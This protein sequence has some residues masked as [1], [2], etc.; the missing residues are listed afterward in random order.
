MRP[1]LDAPHSSPRNRNPVKSDEDRRSRDPQ[2]GVSDVTQLLTL[3]EE[4]VMQNTMVR[5]VRAAESARIRAAAADS[6]RGARPCP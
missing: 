6:H 5:C 3:T 1:S 4:S 2:T